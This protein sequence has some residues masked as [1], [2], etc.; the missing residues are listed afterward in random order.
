MFGGHIGS[1]L[2]YSKFVKMIKFQH[3]A[4]NTGHDLKRCYAKINGLTIYLRFLDKPT[5][6]DMRRLNL[7]A[8][9]L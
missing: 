5:K 7:H 1:Y 6:I 2:K 4:S 3:I 8:F 9:D